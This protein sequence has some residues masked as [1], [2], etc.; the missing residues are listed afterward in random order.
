M[1][2]AADA[3]ARIAAAVPGQRPKITWISTVSATPMHEPPDARYWSDHA[4]NPVRFVE[5]MRT[6]GQTGVSDLVEIGPGGTLLTLGRQNLNENAKAWLGS[7]SKRGELSE[8]L[9]SLGE[10]HRRGFDIDWEEFNRPS[11]RRRVSLPTYPFEHR[12]FW[13]EADAATRPTASSANGLTGV[14]LRSAM[15]DAQFES[16]YSLQ[17]F[18]YLDDHRIYG[19]PVL[20]TTVGLAALRDAAGQYFGSDSVEIANLQYREAM[21]L[22]DSG[23]RIV[24][25]ILTPMDESTA[26]FRFASTSANGAADWRTHMVGVAR[27]ESP[28]RNGQA[29]PLELDRVRQRCASSIPVDRYYET[30]HALGLEYG[31][32]FRGIEMLQRGSG[33]V[34]TRVRLPA[35]LSVDGQSGLH[36]ALLDACLHLY[37]ALVD[38]YGDFTEAANEPRRTYL[39]IS[40][41]RF[42][43]AAGVRAREVWVHGTYRQPGNGNSE[44]F[45]ADIAIYQDDG[46][47]AA[48]IEGLSLKPLPPEALRPHVTTGANSLVQAAKAGPRIRGEG[49]DTAAISSQLRE[50]SG[51]ERRELLVEFV[52]R[53]AMK[54]LGITETIDAARALGELG[55]DSLMSVTL[56]NRL[57][58]ALGIKISAVK[59]IQG[60]SVEQFVDDILAELPAAD[61]KPRPQPIM[62]QPEHSAENWPITV[63]SP[64]DGTTV[65][66]PTVAQPEYSAGIWPIAAD[67]MAGDEARQ[68]P[69][70]VQSERSASKWLINVGPRAAPR[71][72]L[73]CFPFAGGGSAVYRNWTQFIDQT[74]EVVAIEPPG[75][76]GRIT[77]TPVAEM[78]EFVEH[79]LSEMTELLDLPFAFF[80][81]CLGGLTMY[82]TARRLLHT[83]ALRPNICLSRG[84]DRPTGSPIRV[85]SKNASCMIY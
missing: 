26:E 83:T 7:L 22:P 27:K 49:P 45:T 47:F 5:G 29:A 56:L 37:P 30:L 1:R 11:P 82:E 48:A 9:T 35:H 41:E 21:V 72:R 15:P 36:P 46:R 14:R 13:I 18:G 43:C 4:L 74:I 20:P 39:P 60:P 51:T 33:E 53:E 64:A 24:Q 61:D 44:I 28:A 58:A 76:L 81:H 3:F 59:L 10:L 16:T 75:R 12:R 31:A 17:R 50:A 78:H 62:L 8:I 32:S 38:A 77:E 40:V 25:S 63:G 79:L 2:P 23:E 68:R 73:F 69:I 65:P 84:R 55:L 6:L 71:L 19:M 52:R 54:T 85:H 66:P 34:L 70:S 67:P 42:R 80:G 57:E